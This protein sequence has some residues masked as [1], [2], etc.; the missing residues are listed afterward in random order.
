M[1]YTRPLFLIAVSLSLVLG[2][3]MT[4][5]TAQETMFTVGFPQDN[6]ANDWRRAQVMAVEKELSAHPN[7][8]FIYTDAHG[9]TAQNIQDIEDMAD[10]GID[11]LI[12]SPRDI[13]AM[14]PVI[15]E[16]R[17]KGIP[18]ILLTRRIL[19]E[20]YT[21]FVSPSDEKI[22]QRVAQY[23]AEQMQGRGKIF[24][25]QGVPTAS[26]AIKRTE[27]FL[28]EIA[29][30]ANIDVVAVMPANYLRSEAV[31]AIE[32]AI[33]QGTQFDAIFAQSDSMAAG[34]RMALKA[35][36]IDPKSKL[37][38]GIDYIP[39]ARD[40][41]RAGEQS[42]TFTYPTSGKEGAQL[43]VQ[44]LQGKTVPREIEVP[45]EMV[46]RTNVEQVETVF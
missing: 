38:V 17:A 12:V 23:M 3:P 20:D 36:G 22:A 29:K 1:F 31:K 28:A 42:A 46:T 14:T 16:V 8:K 30:H 6:M 25:L 13:A 45:S 15:A 9:D 26:T 18:V 27:G 19:T 10:S 11:L 39:E 37:I 5:T 41:I 21:A 44:I 43:A 24:V 7:I 35:A 34:A 33:E 40:A 4:E 32:Q 2:I